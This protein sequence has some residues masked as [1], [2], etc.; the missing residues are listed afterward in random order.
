MKLIKKEKND[1]CKELGALFRQAREECGLSVIDAAEYWDLPPEKY[2]KVEDGHTSFYFRNT[3]GE[4]VIF[5]SRFGKRLHF[6]TENF[7]TDKRIKYLQTFSSEE[8]QKAL[9]ARENAEKSSAALW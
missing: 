7:N 4:I 2:Q 9:A 1:F 8:L 3:L 5:M 6:S